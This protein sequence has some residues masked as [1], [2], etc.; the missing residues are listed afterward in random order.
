MSA[1]HTH[2]HTYTLPSM[3]DRH[4]YTL[5]RMADRQCRN[6]LHIPQGCCSTRDLCVRQNASIPKLMLSRELVA[7]YKA[8]KHAVDLQD[9]HLADSR[10]VHAFSMYCPF[11]H[12]S[13]VTGVD[14]AAEL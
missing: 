2:T 9:A 12:L 3:A 14:V 6:Q 5:P 11:G 10:T 1:T 7:A 4:T 13:Q 8:D